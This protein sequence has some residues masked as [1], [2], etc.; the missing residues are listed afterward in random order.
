MRYP[1][2]PE[3]K[4]DE[5]LLE[6]LTKLHLSDKVISDAL[7]ISEDTLHRRYADKMDV[8]RGQSK[9]KIAEILYDEAINNRTPWA[10]KMYAH[11]FLG[12]D[13]Q[14]L[15]VEV[16]SQS[17]IQSTPIQMTKEEKLEMIERYRK[18]IQ[19]QPMRSE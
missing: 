16:S 1:T 18:S 3:I 5:T 4:V 10:L 2:K 12:F 6:K 14:S 17:T 19:S 9:A 15:K 8:W 13:P 11:R 7:D